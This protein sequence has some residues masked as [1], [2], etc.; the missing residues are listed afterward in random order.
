MRAHIHPSLWVAVAALCVTSLTCLHVS[1]AQTRAGAR[2]DALA[3]AVYRVEDLTKGL[4]FDPPLISIEESVADPNKVFVGTHNGRIYVSSDGGESWVEDAIRIDRVRF[5]GARYRHRATLSLDKV[6]FLR[7]DISPSPGQVFSF[8]KLI[9]LDR[10]LPQASW[11]I[12]SRFDRDVYGGLRPRGFIAPDSHDRASW[13]LNEVFQRQNGRGVGLSWRGWVDEKAVGDQA[14]QFI[15][16]H[17]RYPDVI[18]AGT[19]GGLHRSLDGGDSWPMVM[20]GGS[21]LTGHVTHVAISPADASEIWVGTKQGLR[22]TRNGGETFSIPTNPFLAE[23]EVRWISFHP[24]DPKVVYVGISWGMLKTTDGGE[25]F[26]VTYFNSWPALSSVRAILI[27]PHRPSRVVLGT[28]DG[29]MLSEDSGGRFRR[30]GGL[31]F[32]EKQVN[33]VLQGFRPGH[34]LASTQSDI[35]QTFDGGETWRSAFF[36]DGPW[37]IRRVIKSATKPYSF[38]LLTQAEIL[39][40]TLTPPERLDDSLFEALLDREYREP[41]IHELIEGGLRLAGVHPSDINAIQKRAPISQLLPEIEV[42]LGQRSAPIS[43][44]V[45]NYLIGEERSNVNDGLFDDQTFAAFAWWDL[46]KAFFHPRELDRAPGVKSSLKLATNLRNEVI[47]LFKER[48]QLI[49]SLTLQPREGRALYMRLLR[50]EELT[51]YLNVLCNGRL[52]PIKASEAYLNH[53]W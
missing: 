5:N 43:F 39:R 20:S 29:L 51:V 32:M 42:S 19:Q 10:Q 36:G 35:W 17:P 40:L 38:L 46:S 24:R 27:D 6:P 12:Q 44:Q 30:I 41:S 21:K 49:R 23:S 11:I 52:P 28:D 22:L 9:D 7:G 45:N 3:D 2:G 4:R 37:K 15:V 18:F 25:T 31:L 1:R 47:S 53:A 13:R 50:L 26:D 14:V 33:S 16:V 48:R 34:Y 8:Q